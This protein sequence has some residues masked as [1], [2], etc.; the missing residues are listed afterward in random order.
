MLCSHTVPQHAFHARS[1]ISVR[2]LAKAR[3]ADSELIASSSRG[4]SLT[5]TVMPFQEYG[6]QEGELRKAADQLC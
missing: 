2:K 4:D 3:A 1:Q 6:L 5:A